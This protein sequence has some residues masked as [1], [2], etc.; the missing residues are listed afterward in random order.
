MRNKRQKMYI[1]YDFNATFKRTPVIIT[2]KLMESATQ[3]MK[4]DS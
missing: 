4:R 3:F 1:Q 2:I